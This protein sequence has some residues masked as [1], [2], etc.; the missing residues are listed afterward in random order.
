MVQIVSSIPRILQDASG[1]Q[2]EGALLQQQLLSLESKVQGVE[3]QTGHSIESLQRIDQLKSRLE[4][5]R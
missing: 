5:L 4:V 2:V 1:L 3:E